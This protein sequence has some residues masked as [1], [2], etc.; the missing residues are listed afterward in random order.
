MLLLRIRELGLK[1]DDSPVEV[2]KVAPTKS[3]VNTNQLVLKFPLVF[4]R[5][6]LVSAARR[7]SAELPGIKYK[8]GARAS[9]RVPGVKCLE[10]IGTRYKAA[11]EL[12]V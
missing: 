11:N 6:S 10:T 9:C 4:K 3:S 5:I 2:S 12:G 7:L 8:M 1:P